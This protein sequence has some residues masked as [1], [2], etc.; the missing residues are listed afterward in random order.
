MAGN[1]QKP[2]SR[3]SPVMKIGFF[4]SAI[5]QLYPTQVYISFELKFHQIHFILFRKSYCSVLHYQ[6][7]KVMTTVIHDY[8]Q[9]NIHLY[10]EKTK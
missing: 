7:D 5:N 6:F 9:H 3:A 2:N 1:G 8:K 4:S 10:P